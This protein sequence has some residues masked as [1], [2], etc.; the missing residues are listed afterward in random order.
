MNARLVSFS[1]DRKRTTNRIVRPRLEAVLAA[2]HRSLAE[3]RG[4]IGPVAV[5]VREAIVPASPRQRVRSAEALRPVRRSTATN[6]LI[7][8]ATRDVFRANG[9]RT[10]RTTKRLAPLVP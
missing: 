1:L 6:I 8:F 10:C 9:T 7:K 5:A 2:V 4:P 3:P